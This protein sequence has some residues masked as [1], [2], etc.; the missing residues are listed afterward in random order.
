MKAGWN[1]LVAL[2]NVGNR[3]K[4]PASGFVLLPSRG[5]GL[6]NNLEQYRKGSD[7]GKTY[8]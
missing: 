5:D 4:F 2:S 3:Q 8:P 6:Y 7:I 1:V